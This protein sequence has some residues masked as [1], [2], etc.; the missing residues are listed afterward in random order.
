MAGRADDGH[1]Y[2]RLSALFVSNKRKEVLTMYFSQ[3]LVARL[4]CD[5]ARDLSPGKLCDLITE[6]IRPS[7]PYLAY[8]G[9]EPLE[10]MPMLDYGQKS[11]DARW[12][13]VSEIKDIDNWV[14][15]N[16]AAQPGGSEG[17]YV[18]VSIDTYDN[19]GRITETPLFVYKTLSEGPD[20]YAAM[21]ALAGMISYAVE[22]FLIINC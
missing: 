17:V 22:M 1:L 20:A 5:N 4:S 15:I 9:K 10:I 2:S 6:A 21:G 3:D 13:K 16:A 19:T 8:P 11:Y 12:H 7:M 18:D 14:R